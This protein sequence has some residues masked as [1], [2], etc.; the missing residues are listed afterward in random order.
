VVDADRILVMDGG[1]IIEQGRHRAL[2]T[3]G[4]AY[5]AMWELQQREAILQGQ[6]E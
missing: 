6:G 3:Q 2:L 1:R 4:G 5:A